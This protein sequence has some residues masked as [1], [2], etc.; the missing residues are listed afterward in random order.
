MTLN[1]ERSTQ[2]PW[3][4]VSKLCQAGCSLKRGTKSFPHC[5]SLAKW[6]DCFL[7][8]VSPKQ[9]I[10]PFGTGELSGGSWLEQI[11]FTML[12]L[13]TDVK[14]SHVFCLGSFVQ[15]SFMSSTFQSR[16]TSTGKFS[17]HWHF[18]AHNHFEQQQQQNFLKNEIKEVNETNSDFL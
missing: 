16:K 17:T 13:G 9:S 2:S 8:C 14:K 10:Q 6:A 7:Q 3:R 15:K 11:L 1:L 18:Y 4:L 5:P 12:P